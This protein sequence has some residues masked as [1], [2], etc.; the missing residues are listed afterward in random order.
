MA[1]NI[2]IQ[3]PYF[4]FY[5]VD[6]CEK[7]TVQRAVTVVGQVFQLAFAAVCDELILQ[8][9]LRR[10][11]GCTVNHPSEMEHSCLMVDDDESMV[12]LL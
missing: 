10:C 9:L 6:E 8:E 7:V 11:F 1:P 2:E 12:S 3:L 4:V 5:P